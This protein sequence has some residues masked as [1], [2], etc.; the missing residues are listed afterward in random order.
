MNESFEKFSAPLTALFAAALMVVVFYVGNVSL[1]FV[2]MLMYFPFVTLFVTEGA[3]LTLGASALSFVAMSALFGV[4]VALSVVPKALLFALVMGWIIERRATL[5]EE[6]IQ[7]AMVFVVGTLIFMVVEDALTRGGGILATYQ[8]EVERTIQQMVSELK[9][10]PAITPTMLEQWQVM[11]RRLM[12]YMIYLIPGLLFNEGFISA[13][14]TS[15]FSRSFLNKAMSE[16]VEP[17]QIEKYV[18]GREILLGFI[19]LTVV[20]FMATLVGLPSW[21]AVNVLLIGLTLFTFQGFAVVGAWLTAHG[22]PGIL[23]GIL[24]VLALFLFLPAVLV[25]FVGIVKSARISQKEAV[26]KGMM[27]P[28]WTPLSEETEGGE[29]A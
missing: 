16:D 22:T 21:V 25:F 7:P 15:V 14:V 23:R 28:D 2:Q 6:I 27:D 5:A 9:N 18:L 19:L 4:D 24:Y 20:L 13:I 17:F 10:N 29:D 12:T 3:I 11:M 26:E 1:A 8:Q